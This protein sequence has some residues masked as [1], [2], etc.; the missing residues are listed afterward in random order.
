MKCPDCKTVEMYQT[1]SPVGPTP[2]I[3]T[4]CGL[5]IDEAAGKI[6]DSVD[7]ELV[8]LSPGVIFNDPPDLP[9]LMVFCDKRLSEVARR[10]IQMAIELSIKDRK[11]LIVEVSDM[12][13][14]QCVNGQWTEIN[15]PRELAKRTMFD[16]IV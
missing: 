5:R 12:R 2:F 14:F 11:P 8:Y 9:P 16:R 1:C 3:C 13:V 6:A 15:A 4:K 7:E 10:N